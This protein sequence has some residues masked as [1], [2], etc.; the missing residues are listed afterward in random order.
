MIMAKL[1]L[2]LTREE[3]EIL[4]YQAEAL[5]YSLSRY[6]KFLIAQKAA[7]SLEVSDE[8]VSP[9]AIARYEKMAQDIDDGKIETYSFNSVDELMKHLHSSNK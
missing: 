5:G 1:Q 2:T 8:Y 6:V 9:Q 4:T 7:E 3:A